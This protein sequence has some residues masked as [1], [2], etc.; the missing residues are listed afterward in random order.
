MAG[1]EILLNKETQN[2]TIPFA[3]FVTNLLHLCGKN[4]HSGSLSSIK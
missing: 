2:Q 1:S 4:I 3:R